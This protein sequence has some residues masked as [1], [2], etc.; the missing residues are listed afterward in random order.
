MSSFSPNYHSSESRLI[1]SLCYVFLIVVPVLVL[2][3][4][5]RGNR[6]LRYHGYQGL[7]TGVLFLVAYLLLI[8]GATWILLNIPCIGWSFACLAPFIYVAGFGLQFYWAYL[9]YQG[10]LFSIPIISAIASAYVQD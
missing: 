7:A 8:P 5:L 9:A 3:S 2:V 1:A 4:D 10:Q 6:F